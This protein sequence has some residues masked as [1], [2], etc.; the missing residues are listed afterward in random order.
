[1]TNEDLM[2]INDS[3]LIMLYHDEDEFAK[4]IIYYKYKFIIDIVIKKYSGILTTLGFDYEEIYSEASIGFSNALKTYEEDKDASLATYITFCI[5]R[6]IKNLIKKYSRE[7]YNGYEEIFSL[8]FTYFDN[9]AR[10]VDL[11]NDG[12]DAD[13][14][15]NM[16]EAEEY[17]ELLKKIKAELTEKEYEVFI[18]LYEG[19]NYQEIAKILDKVPKQID[20]TIQ[21]IKLKIK[22]LLIDKN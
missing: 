22:N 8:D 12:G 20:N 19:L 5:E 11:L 1:M 3:E 2:S 13:P 6:R 21:R 9:Q 14:L 7:K 18:L 4:N 16:T 17:K 15:K 10:L